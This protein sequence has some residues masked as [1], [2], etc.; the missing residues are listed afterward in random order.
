VDLE[1]TVR[2]LIEPHP[3]VGGLRLVGSRAHGSPTVLSDW[4]F[5]V[6]SD[7]VE[8]VT[9][10]LPTLVAPL[11]P[12]VAQWDRLSE[13]SAYYMLILPEGV[14]VDFVLDRPPMLEPPWDVRPETLAPL[15]G[16]FWDWILWLGGKQL[17]GED[18]LVRS[19]LAGLMFEHLLG[20]LGVA[21]A[22]P[23]IGDAIERYR[24]ARAARESEFG[25][26][27][28]RR[29]EAAVLP[30]LEAAGLA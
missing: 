18:E 15:D 9:A 13:E 25:I 17:R 14:K 20:P 16:H 3:S 7:D 29:V 1:A 23:S 19:M 6:E 10:A 8:A 22:P 2:A 28:P 12:L 26:E 11:E 30:R 5:L 4:D 27:V 24:T 21:E